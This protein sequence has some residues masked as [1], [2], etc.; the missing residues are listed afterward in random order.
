MRIKPVYDNRR[1]YMDLLLLGD[2]Q[3]EMVNR[4]IDTGEM[5]IGRVG[6]KAVA[7]CVVTREGSGLVAVDP[8]CRRRGYGRAMLSYIEARYR[9]CAVQLGTGETPVTIDFYRACGYT[10]SHRIPGFFTDNYDHPIWENGVQLVDMVY[11]K[12]VF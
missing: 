4:Y 7:V 9:E 10:Y 11:L 2:E 6:C 1:R 5:F 12:K 3:E 8:A